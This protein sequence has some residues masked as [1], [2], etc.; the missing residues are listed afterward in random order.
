MISEV[1]ADI[2]ARIVVNS[3]Y[4]VR[5]SSEEFDSDRFYREHY[6]RVMRFLPR[7]QKILIGEPSIARKA[8]ELAPLEVLEAK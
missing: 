8:E 7:F 1:V 6:K 2:S 3:L 5:R 4:R